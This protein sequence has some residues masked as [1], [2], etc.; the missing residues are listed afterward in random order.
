MAQPAESD[1]LPPPSFRDSLSHPLATLR[2][3]FGLASRLRRALA[4]TTSR[5]A[6]AQAI[7][8]CCYGA[9][10]VPGFLL[11]A[12]VMAVAYLVWGLAAAILAIQASLAGTDA[13]RHPCSAPGT[14][15]LAW[16]ML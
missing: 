1:E 4:R 15:L 10:L 12:L 14:W 3:A 11:V 2:R 8:A 9:A 7:V 6:R 5:V 13:L 16:G